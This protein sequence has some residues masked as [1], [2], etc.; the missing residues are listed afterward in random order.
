MLKTPTKKAVKKTI[1]KKTVVSQ[2]KKIQKEI[3]NDIKVLKKRIISLTH[4]AKKKYD[5]TD[6]KTKK[7][8]VAGIA[9]AAAILSSLILVGK[10][11]RRKK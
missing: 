2:S 1:A 11:K 9:S 6:D 3:T 5:S 4:E 8:I 7:Q 10:V